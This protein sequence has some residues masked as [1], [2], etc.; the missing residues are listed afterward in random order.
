MRFLSLVLLMGCSVVAL[1]APPAIA[2]C[3]GP[4]IAVSDG[5]V[6]RGEIL[7][8]VGEGWG[9]NCHDTG[10]PPDAHGALG[11][12]LDD[13]EVAFVQDGKETIVARGSA[14]DDYRFEA[15]VTVPASLRPGIARLLARSGDHGDY[16]RPTVIVT[17][18]K[19]IAPQGPA[20][21]N[22]D[23]DRDDEPSAAAPDGS[24][25]SDGSAARGWL[26]GGVLAVLTAR[27]RPADP[28]PP[29]GTGRLAVPS[30]WVCDSSHSCC[31]SAAA[32]SPSPR[33]QRV[34]IA[35]GRASPSPT[36][37]SA[38]A[39][40]FESSVRAGATTVTTWAFPRTRTAPWA[41]R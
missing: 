31:W 9:D 41:T 28:P 10:V 7:R 8:V 18:A 37:T 2:S 22:L 3:I 39:R 36:A 6:R 26:I 24:D 16:E 34:R 5:D 30:E 20:V 21:R 23:E 13:I 12:P 14:D 33:H 32:L 27:G 29:S 17:K 40:S 35:R 19:P 4:S 1:A 38:A 25:D 11:D 15:L